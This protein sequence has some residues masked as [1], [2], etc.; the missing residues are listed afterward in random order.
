MHV[1][2]ER[3]GVGGEKLCKEKDVH[4]SWSVGCVGEKTNQEEGVFRVDKSQ[5]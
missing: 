5:K 2:F 3:W 1:K 4:G